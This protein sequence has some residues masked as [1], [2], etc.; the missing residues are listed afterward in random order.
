MGWL[1]VMQNMRVRRGHAVGGNH[2]D[3]DVKEALKI[4]RVE[5]CNPSYLEKLVLA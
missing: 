5:R 4:S 2:L 3:L 1:Q